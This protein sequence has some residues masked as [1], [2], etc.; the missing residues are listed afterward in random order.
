MRAASG[1]PPLSRR[2]AGLGLANVGGS[3]YPVFGQGVYNFW[4]FTAVQ[5]FA[6]YSLLPSEA[7]RTRTGQGRD[8]VNF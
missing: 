8:G 5:R 6:V 1:S 2:G 3:V 4:Y 7:C